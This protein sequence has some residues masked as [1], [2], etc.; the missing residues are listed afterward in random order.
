VEE[1]QD[2]GEAA[3][4]AAYPAEGLRLLIGPCGGGPR[5]CGRIGATATTRSDGETSDYG[6]F[7]LGGEH[8]GRLPHKK[9]TA[10]SWLLDTVETLRRRREIVYC[11]YGVRELQPPRSSTP[12]RSDGEIRPGIQD[13]ERVWRR[14]TRGGE[15]R[16]RGR[17]RHRDPKLCRSRRGE[18]CREIV[19]ISADSDQGRLRGA[20]RG[21]FLAVSPFT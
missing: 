14:R 21:F 11:Q 6:Q 9:G 18:S 20:D 3:R 17:R 1:G 7:R 8:G 5:I 19:T 16:E 13:Q 12:A 10:V 15:Q 4:R 2:A